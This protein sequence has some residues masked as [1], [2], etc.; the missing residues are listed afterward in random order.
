MVKENI[1]TGMQTFP[2]A[3]QLEIR[4]LLKSLLEIP[5]TTVLRRWALIPEV[6]PA[7]AEWLLNRVAQVNLSSGSPSRARLCWACLRQQK[8]G[9]SAA[10]AS[11][12]ERLLPLPSEQCPKHHPVPSHRMTPHRAVASGTQISGLSHWRVH[13]EKVQA[14]KD[15]RLQFLQADRNLLRT[16]ILKHLKA[17]DSHPAGVCTFLPDGPWKAPSA[18]L[19]P[20]HRQVGNNHWARF[21]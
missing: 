3:I 10:A 1:L 17:P 21:K 4:G 14:I 12:T 15:F 18:A 7:L 5:T 8:R 6:K 20:A 16:N 19:T 2:K 11:L 9:W 13:H